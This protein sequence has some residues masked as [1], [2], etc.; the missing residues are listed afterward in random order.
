MTTTYPLARRAAFAALLGIAL[1]LILNFSHASAQSSVTIINALGSQGYYISQTAGDEMKGAGINDADSKLKNAVNDLKGKGYD[2]K[3]AM[4]VSN[5]VPNQYGTLANYCQYLHDYLNM[6]NGILVLTAIDGGAAATTNKLSPADS[7]TLFNAQRATFTKNVVDGT[8]AFATA[9]DD[10]ILGNDSGQRTSFITIAVIVI[11]VILG[12][13]IFTISGL[14]ARWA[15]RLNN[16]KKLSS[17]LSNEV[18][19]MGSN[20]DFLK[21]QNAKAYDQV[22]AHLNPGNQLLSDANTQLAKLKSPGFIALAFQY[23]KIDHDLHDVEAALQSAKGEIDQAQQIYNANWSS[24][25]PGN[26][27]VSAS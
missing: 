13:A 5:D 10:K 21:L 1:A 24:S 20:V 6:G 2:V 9:V 23:S 19:Q 12:I 16:A 3:L 8:V 14:N 22:T 27:K 25:N 18:V 11:L 7:T 4:I 17:D 26:A 15:I